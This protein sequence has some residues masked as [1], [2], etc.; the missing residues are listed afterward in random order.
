MDSEIAPRIVEG[1]PECTTQCPAYHEGEVKQGDVCY[2]RASGSCQET[3]ENTQPGD[4]CA[5]MLRRLLATRTEA[6]KQIEVMRKQNLDRADKAEEER[7]AAIADRDC[8]AAKRQGQ[9]DAIAELRAELDAADK[10]GFA[11]SAAFESC[12]AERDAARRELCE[13]NVFINGNGGRGYSSNAEMIEARNRYAASRE[14]AYLYEGKGEGGGMKYEAAKA[15]AA[16]ERI[17]DR[18]RAEMIA[19][20]RNPMGT[21]RG[22]GA[23]GRGSTR[24]SG[25]CQ[26]CVSNSLKNQDH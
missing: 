15:E 21:C 6:L 10:A 25:F 11:I 19:E 16:R 18:E 8:E 14:W 9:D 5:P 24:T 2:V 12:H 23:P 22:C 3:Y 7:D 4:M 13:D 17:T 20:A 26:T 1:E